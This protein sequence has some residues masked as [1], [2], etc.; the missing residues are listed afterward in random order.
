[1]GAMLLLPFQTR[2]VQ[3]AGLVR[4]AVDAARA[5]RPGAAGCGP[6]CGVQA[7][8]VVHTVSWVGG[9]THLTRTG[10]KV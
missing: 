2:L 10:L 5:G 3:G 6:Q 1:M 8:A 7:G 4:T 9:R